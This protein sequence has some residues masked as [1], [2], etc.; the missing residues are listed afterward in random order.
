[1]KPV[2]LTKS[3]FAT[4][5]KCPRKLDYA[6]DSRYFNANAH[7]VFLESLAEG[8]HQVGELARKMF[9]Q[10]H[11]V[12]DVSADDQVRTTQSLLQR[13]AVTV[14]GDDPPR[15]PPG[16]LRRP[17]NAPAIGWISSK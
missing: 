4:A 5:L 10:G 16:S 12:T 3:R 17:A 2:A 13:P 11:L 9:P 6:R 15:Q 1:V 8:G 7:N 14:R